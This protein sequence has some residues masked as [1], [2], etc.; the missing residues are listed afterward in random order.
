[1]RPTQI[2]G[3]IYGGCLWRGLLSAN[4]APIK[5]MNL[6]QSEVIRKFLDENEPISI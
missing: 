4:L 3:S 1:M 5:R 6:P 2:R